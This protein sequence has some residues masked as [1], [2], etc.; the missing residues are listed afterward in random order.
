M[1]LWDKTF[2]VDLVEATGRGAEYSWLEPGHQVTHLIFYPVPIFISGTT[3]PENF[4]F[5]LTL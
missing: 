3:F 2:F 4:R 5:S 1:R